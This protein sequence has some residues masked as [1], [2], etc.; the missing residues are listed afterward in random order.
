MAEH[1]RGRVMRLEL[2][3]ASCQSKERMLGALLDE[4]DGVTAYYYDTDTC[5]LTAYVDHFVLDEDDLL[6]AVIAS[7]LFPVTSRVVSEASEGDTH[8]C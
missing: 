6:R 8:A 3:G 5:T 4:V 1:Y 7:G 2:S